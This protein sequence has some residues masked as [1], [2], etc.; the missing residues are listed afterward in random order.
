MNYN[1]PKRNT[2]MAILAWIAGTVVAPTAFSSDFDEGYFTKDQARP[3]LEKTLRIHLSPS[4]E[5]LSDEERAAVKNLIEVGQ[6]MQRLY[7][8]S[9]HPE[10]I[11]A[12]NELVRLSRDSS[13]PE[14]AEMLLDLYRLSKGPIVTTLDNSRQ[15]FLPVANETA[16][17]N[18]YPLAIEKD[19]IEQVLTAQPELRRSLLHLRYVVRRNGTETIQ[20]DLAT[21]EQNPALSVLHPGLYDRLLAAQSEPAAAPLYALPYSVAYADQLLRAFELLNNAAELLLENDPA[22]SRYLSNRARD[23]LSD[24]YESG[25]ASWVTGRFQNLNAQIGS[26][27]TYDDHLYGVKSFFAVSLLVRD[28]ERSAELA[29]ATGGLQKLE[30]ALP[31][32][33]SRKIREDIPVGVYNI[34]ADFGQARGTNTATILPNESYLARQ[35]GRTILLR[36][37]ILTDPNL[38]ANSKAAFESA[39]HEEHHSD[40]TA[41]AKLYRTLW[42][43]I[44]HYL[45][46]DRTADGRDLG[47]A[48]QDASDLYEEMKS[49][50]VSLF[51]VQQLVDDGYYTKPAAQAVYAAGILRVLQKN[52]PRRDQPY[53]TMQLM[54]WNWFLEHDV[55][56]FDS[57]SETLRINY[58]RYH[59][60]VESL[61]AEVL[62]IQ[63][64]G[65]RNQA[66]VFVQ[67]H[68][69]WDP[70]LHGVIAENM[71]AREVYRYALV[72][73][74]AL[75]D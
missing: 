8:N 44:G 3:I 27:E 73:Y 35:Y 14:R 19:E 69:A 22:F 56:Q 26:Y 32:D 12:H 24:D 52:Q 72:T 38:F 40:L 4:L 41:E 9:R 63:S 59:G 58:E 43:E 5:S 48:L 50:L 68:T 74:E 20:A 45:G 16:G 65:D 42:H 57:A 36:G 23:L 6:I 55:L 34:V 39:I 1:S 46:V 62:A 18:V 61:L 13:D 31:Y 49:D 15:A 71:R 17:K 30:D 70:K 21:L 64:A 7:E 37:N 54:Q 25:D 33:S 28:H 11:T 75:D 10:A 53:Q 29:A 67:E 51:S 2:R 47:E 66:E 60:A